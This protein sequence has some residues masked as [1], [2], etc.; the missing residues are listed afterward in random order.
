M[1][2]QRVLVP[3][4]KRAHDHTLCIDGALSEAESACRRQRLRFTALRRRVLELV[5]TRHTPVKAY[6]ILDKLRREGRSAAP[7]TVYRALDFLLEAGLVHR[8][9]SLNAYVGCGGPAIPHVGQFLIC[10]RC[11]AVA[12]IDVPAVAKALAA[13][14]R[15][16]GF[17]TDRQTIE[18]R[19]LCAHCGGSG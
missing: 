4:K 1:S 2:K 10:R 11:R 17:R 13:D 15:R 16:L 7:P 19:G 18:V 12:E 14:A 8:I 9:E 6:D 3:F 5:W